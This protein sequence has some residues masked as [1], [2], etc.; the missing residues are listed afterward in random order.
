M[1]CSEA[2]VTCGRK[3]SWYMWCNQARWVGTCKYYFKDIANKPN[4]AENFAV[5]IVFAITQNAISQEPVAQSSWGFHQIK[6]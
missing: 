1:K 3:G 5:F 6:A 2:A 4:K